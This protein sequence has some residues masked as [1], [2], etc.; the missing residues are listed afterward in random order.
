M[1]N[2]LLS[3]STS[4]SFTLTNN[5]IAQ[6][7]VIILNIASGAT[8]NSYLT[9]VDSISNGSCRIQLRNIQQSGSLSEA[10][11]LNFAVIKSTTS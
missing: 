11:V 1:S 3:H 9:E 7:D 5:K 6:D 10:V 4:V 2:A 8:T